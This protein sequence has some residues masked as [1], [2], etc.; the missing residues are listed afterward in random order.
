MVIKTIER[1]IPAIRLITDSVI[2]SKY[3]EKYNQD[4]EKFRRLKNKYSGERCFLFGTGPSLKY[5]DLSVFKNEITFGVNSLLW[6]D[7]GVEF[8]FFGL[9][10]KNKKCLNGIFGKKESV[11]FLFRTAAR[12]YFKEY[13]WLDN[14]ITLNTNGLILQKKALPEDISKKVYGGG[15]TIIVPCLQVCFYLGFKEVYLVG[16][17]CSY[18]GDVHFKGNERIPFTGTKEKK[19]WA[20]VFKSYEIL[21]REFEKNNKKIYNSTMGGNLEVFERKNLE[22]IL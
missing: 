2:D 9:T 19:H 8:N 12:M 4:R 6:K 18:S 20:K 17:D 11:L 13:P 1:K 10:G 5:M 16:C 22:D 15:G 3:K 21:R 7:T 14:V